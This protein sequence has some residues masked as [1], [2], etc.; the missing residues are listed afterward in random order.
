LHTFRETIERLKQW[1][2]LHD[3]NHTLL[4]LAGFAEN[5]IDSHAPDYNP[6]PAL[7][8]D[9]NFK[10][11]VQAAHEMGYRVMIHTNILAMTFTHRLFPKFKEHQVVDAFGRPQ[12]WGL[13]MDGDWLA[14]PYFAY[15]NPGAKEWGELMTGVIGDL[16]NLFKVDAVFLDQTLLAFNV[17]R[18]P[19][20]LE[21]MRQHIQRLQAAFPKIL[22]A[23]EGQHEQTLSA[24][25]MAQI[26][27]ID[28]IA[29]VHAMDGQAPWRRAHPVSTCLFGKYTRFTP[30]LLT[31]H[32][33]HPMFKFQEA[34]YADLGVLPS[35]VLYHSS[36]P[37]DTPEAR[38]MIERAKRLRFE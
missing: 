23:G 18:G 33:S 34:A 7:G 14:E 38:Q 4:Y 32:P 16:I 11:L 26:H 30:H 35:L 3:P 13:D 12:T 36:Q 19:N 22:F 6:S 9:Q 15:I 1:S 29:E 25:P 28:S 17:S 5:G 8:G 20:F 24:L 37:M 31:K 2:K 10:E 27:G 21:G